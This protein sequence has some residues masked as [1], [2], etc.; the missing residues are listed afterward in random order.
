M[1]YKYTQ[2]QMT[3]D[4]CMSQHIMFIKIYIAVMKSQKVRTCTRDTCKLTWTGM[5]NITV[6]EALSPW[7]DNQVKTEDG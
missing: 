1:V 2:T 7:A 4:T 6:Y 5:A 3:D